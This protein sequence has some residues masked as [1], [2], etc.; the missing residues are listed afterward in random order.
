LSRSFFR[1]PPGPQTRK[2]NEWI[3]SDAING[4]DLYTHLRRHHKRRRRQCRYGSGRGLIPGRVGISKRPEAVDHT[5][6]SYQLTV[7]MPREAGVDG[8]G[9]LHHISVRGIEC[10]KIFREDFD[11]RG[12]LKRVGKYARTVAA[13]SV[14]CYWANRELGISTVELARRLQLAQSTATQSVARGEKIVSNS[15]LFSY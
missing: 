7:A 4:G 6:R 8:P 10:R 15:S 9:A 14:L 2:R 12:V 1:E 5:S 11:C 13:R 3:Y